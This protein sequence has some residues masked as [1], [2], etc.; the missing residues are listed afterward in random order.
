MAGAN[1]V[2]NQRQ[3]RR[4]QRIVEVVDLVIDPVDGQGVL[5]QIVGADRQE[6]QVAGEQVGTHR[7][8]RN[9]DHATHRQ[10]LIKGQPT[11]AQFLLGFRHQ[12]QYLEDLL[13]RAQ[14]RNHHPHRPVRRSAQDSP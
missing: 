6:I 10:V 1:G 7:R 2:M 12:A 9:L 8:C 14:H 13:H 5:D 11:L 3:H 4:V